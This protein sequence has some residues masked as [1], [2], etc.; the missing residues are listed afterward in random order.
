MLKVIFC[1]FCFY[2][3][4]GAIEDTPRLSLRAEG[5]VK[6]SA[7]LVKLSVGVTSE[8]ET[9]KK[10]LEENS[11][12]MAK[13]VESLKGLPL[14]S[15][16]FE[17]GSFS[18]QPR[19]KPKPLK[20]SL[21][22]K[23]QIEAYQVQNTLNIALEELEA[24]PELIDTLVDVGANAVGDLQFVL[25]NQETERQKAIELAFERGKKDALDLSN[26]A[27]QNLKKI[28]FLSLDDSFVTPFM[29][30]SGALFARSGDLPAIQIGEVEVRASVN[31][32]YEISSKVD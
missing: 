18:I 29:M 9:S 16:K 31:L 28:L 21:E 17:T 19:Y 1:L 25:K 7:D 30:K 22:W 32:I 11:K 5:V 8:G 14:K 24:L 15:L 4:F 3:L 13:V 10:A 20:T 23:P 2:P 27:G 12:K 26:A 6:K